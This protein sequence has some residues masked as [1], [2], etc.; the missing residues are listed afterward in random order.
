MVAHFATQDIILKPNLEH[1]TH[2]TPIAKK[3]PIYGNGQG[4]GDSPSQWNQE[5]AVLNSLFQQEARGVTII[6]PVTKAQT[7]VAMTAFAD[8]TTIHGNNINNQKS[9]MELAHDV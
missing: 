1:P 9:P 2:F 5:S 8:D 4:A 7:T 6:H 3:T